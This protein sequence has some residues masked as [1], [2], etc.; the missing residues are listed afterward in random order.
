MIRTGTLIG[1]VAWMAMAGAAAAAE[2]TSP[3]AND[4][5]Q[6][7]QLDLRAPDVTK[8]YTPEQIDRMLAKPVGK[9]IEEVQVEGERGRRAPVTPR[10]WP[11]IAAPL[12]ALLHPTQ[13]WRIIAPLPPDQTRYMDTGPRDATTGFLEPAAPPRQ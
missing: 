2:R 5:P 3:P 10:V 9:D 8:L 11:G 13:A 7:K 1:G 6:R 12:W 4:P